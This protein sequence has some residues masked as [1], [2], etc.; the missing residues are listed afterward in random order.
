MI[1]KRYINDFL[2]EPIELEWWCPETEEEVVIFNNKLGGT[3]E[4]S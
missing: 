4:N 1:H 3:N 2:D